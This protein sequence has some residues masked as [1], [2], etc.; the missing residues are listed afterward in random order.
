MDS[1]GSRMC[2]VAEP[3]LLLGSG[4]LLVPVTSELGMGRLEWFGTASMRRDNGHGSALN[5]TPSTGERVPG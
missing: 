2:R 4:S 5:G 3:T 1:R